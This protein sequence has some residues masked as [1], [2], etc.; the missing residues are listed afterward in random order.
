[1]RQKTTGTG[2]TCAPGGGAHRGHLHLAK[3]EEDNQTSE[4][5][6]P[7]RDG[8]TD[9]SATCGA[10]LNEVSRCLERAAILEFLF[11]QVTR[12]FVGENGREPTQLVVALTGGPRPA[13][14]KTVVDVERELLGLIEH[15]RS[16]A[17]ALLDA[18][19]DL[20]D[21]V[22][23]PNAEAEVWALKSSTTTRIRKAEPHS[24][25]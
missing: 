4:T 12:H 14:I 8:T 7:S 1:M 17:R 9:A 16:Q 25:G 3:T 10:V 15:E 22:K 6:P 2:T 23:M 13:E 11:E 24:R 20:P 18:W 21:G 5:A 19:V